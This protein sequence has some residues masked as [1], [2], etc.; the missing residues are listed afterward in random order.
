MKEAQQEEEGPWHWML[1][2]GLQLWYVHA[3]LPWLHV[4]VGLGLSFKH[5]EEL[6]VKIKKKPLASKHPPELAWRRGPKALLHECAVPNVA[7]IVL[8]MGMLTLR[9]Q[10]KPCG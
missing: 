7:S 4:L 9:W 6:A 5:V 3:S 1:R 2:V 8:G 10:V